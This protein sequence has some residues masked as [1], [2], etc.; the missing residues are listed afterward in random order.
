MVAGS[1]VPPSVA[2][3]TLQEAPLSSYILLSPFKLTL[4][5]Q[6]HL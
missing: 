1:F 3:Y 2:S 4:L 5:A 6:Y